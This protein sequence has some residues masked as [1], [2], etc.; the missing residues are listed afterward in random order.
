MVFW[1]LTERW[2][3]VNAADVTEKQAETKTEF[4]FTLQFTCYRF[5]PVRLPHLCILDSAARA[6][7]G[8]SDVEKRN[9]AAQFK[10]KIIP[11]LSPPT[12]LKLL[13]NLKKQERFSSPAEGQQTLTAS[14]LTTAAG[15]YG[16]CF[17]F[18]MITLYSCSLLSHPLLLIIVSPFSRSCA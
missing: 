6:S 4:A 14:S 7:V 10:P 11:L 2:I 12:S 18:F 5:L 13:C 17:F 9:S 8:G 1:S 3:D 15:L 16:S